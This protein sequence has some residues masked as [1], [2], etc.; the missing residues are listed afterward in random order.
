[1]D[2]LLKKNGTLDEKQYCIKH[3]KHCYY[4][5]P[6][7]LERRKQVTIQDFNNIKILHKQKMEVFELMENSNDLKKLKELAKLVTRIEYELQKAWHFKKN[8][9]MHKWYDVPQCECPKLDNQERLGTKYQIISETCSI[10]R[11]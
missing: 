9:Y 7:L 11:K 5:N 8:K 4:I 2:L 3:K 6:F 10:H 1:M